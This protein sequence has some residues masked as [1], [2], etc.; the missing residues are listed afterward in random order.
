MW[1]RGERV[2]MPNHFFE[3]KRTTSIMMALRLRLLL[4]PVRAQLTAATPTTALRVRQRHHYLRGGLAVGGRRSL[5]SSGKQD[6]YSILGVS[7]EDHLDVIKSTY[8]DL[9]RVHHPDVRGGGDAELF[10][11]LASAMREILVYR[12][13][14]D[15][16]EM[17]AEGQEGKERKLYRTFDPGFVFEFVRESVDAAKLR[18][19]VQQA[20]RG[21]GKAGPDM[22]DWFFMAELVGADDGQ[23]NKTQQPGDGAT[24]H[25]RHHLNQPTPSIEASPSSNKKSN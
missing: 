12:L 18:Q 17:A 1:V 25:H 20:T 23:Q 8:L 2:M 16:K 14:L 9:A 24:S 21:M 13:Q 11:E 3:L 15:T 7:S 5:S 19:E 6:P 4:R 22:G 10:K